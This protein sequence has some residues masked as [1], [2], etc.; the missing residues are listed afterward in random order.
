[1]VDFSILDAEDDAAMELYEAKL[2]EMTTMAAILDAYSKLKSVGLVDPLFVDIDS[3]SSDQVSLLQFV[4]KDRIRMYAKKLCYLPLEFFIHGLI[5]V[6]HCHDALVREKVTY[7]EVLKWWVSEGELALEVEKERKRIE[8]KVYS[9]KF[10]VVCKKSDESSM[11]LALN[12]H[13]P[14]LVDNAK[15]AHKYPIPSIKVMDHNSIKEF[16]DMY[17]KPLISNFSD[18]VSYEFELIEI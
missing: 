6:M 3:T 16:F 15:E 17:I 10:I 7:F 13:V 14:N 2:S 4:A 12:N 5:S 1:M 8:D 9:S 11:Y 18:V